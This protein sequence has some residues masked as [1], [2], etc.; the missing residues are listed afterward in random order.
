MLT[1]AEIDEIMA[2][3]RRLE[4]KARR[5]VRESFSG[6]YLSSFRG[7]GLDF[8][9][10]REYQH[11]DEV[12]FID[13]NVTARM[14]QPYVRKFHEEREASVVIAVD[15][16]GSVDYGSV[17]YSKR[18]I[19][20]EA[21][22]VL[23]FSALQNGDKIGLLLFAEEPFLY[24]PPEKGTRHL[25]RMIRE[26]LAAKPPK[27]TTSIR[28]ACEFLVRTLRR[29]S[30]VFLIS[31]FQS[32]PLDKP[33]GKLARK[34]DT[35]ALRTGDPLERELPKAGVVTFVDPETG[36]ETKVNTSNPNLRMAYG[37]MAARHREGVR[38]VFR[39]HGIDH[40]PLNTDGDIFMALHKLLKRRSRKR[41]R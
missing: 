13:W 5:L 14:Q 23:G 28:A 21:A 19:A 24:I 26:I 11:G 6:Q 20:A 40:A 29:K 7:Q 34:H 38:G 9:D 16:S 30:V 32:D 37:K 2:R 4:I 12:R 25:L 35:I 15:I 36:F 3:V 33:L 18:E 22:A 1:D 31:D 27:A 10:Y 8:D 41:S 17:S 39:K